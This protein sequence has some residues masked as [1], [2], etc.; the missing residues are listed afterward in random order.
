[1]KKIILIV[2][3][4]GLIPF[5]HAADSSQADPNG[6]VTQRKFNKMIE[7]MRH[8]YEQLHEIEAKLKDHSQSK[9]Q[10]L[11]ELADLK[12]KMAN[13]SGGSGGGKSAAADDGEIKAC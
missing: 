11:K 10:T 12:K 13:F 2:L 6:F 4:F 1:M 5:A 9:D 8:F 7:I 3:L